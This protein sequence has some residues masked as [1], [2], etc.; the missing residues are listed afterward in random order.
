MD[1]GDI[2]AI[3]TIIGVELAQLDHYTDTQERVWLPL[4][5][6]KQSVYHAE[7]SARWK[8]WAAPP[9][10]QEHRLGKEGPSRPSPKFAGEDSPKCSLRSGRITAA[11]F[12]G[13]GQSD[14]L[15]NQGIAGHGPFAPDAT[16]NIW[17]DFVKEVFHF[18][19]LVGPRLRER[20]DSERVRLP[21]VVPAVAPDAG[22]IG[23]VF[24]EAPFVF[25]P[26]QRAVH[27]AAYLHC[28]DCGRQTGKVKGEYNFL[29]L[30]RQDCSKLK[31]NK[32][33]K[34]TVTA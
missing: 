33:T 20:P 6:L 11:D 31:K 26:H 12:Y 4:P 21:P 30:K 10:R 28:F 16:W 13:N 23:M 9:E 34:L 29:H 32:N 15:A 3:L 5:G 1:L 2:V 22:I 8:N 18:W 24:P 14:I 27:H 17:E 25:G 19:R 7:L